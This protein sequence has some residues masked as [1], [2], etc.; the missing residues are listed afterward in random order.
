M[1]QPPDRTVQLSSLLRDGEAL[2]WQGSPD[3]AVRFTSAD[4]ILIPFSLLWGGFALVW[5]G[6][7]WSSNA[8]F[9]FRLWGLPFLAVGFYV[10]IGRFMVSARRKSKTTYAVT[11][12]RAI[13]IDDRSQVRYV[14]LAHVLHETTTQKQGRA[15]TVN[16]RAPS[17]PPLGRTG[18]AQDSRLGGTWF[19]SNGQQRPPLF[20]FLGV[21]DAQ[22]L[23][24]ALAD[25]PSAK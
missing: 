8:P 18:L 20:I 10:T 17:A 9:F 14:E 6:V 7:V 22:A 13:I 23:L 12:E 25:A 11:S 3:P 15:V 1:P 2:S 5:N 24:V 19:E 16:F 4:R 21:S